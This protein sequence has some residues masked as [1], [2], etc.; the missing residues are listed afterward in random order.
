MI[1][2]IDESATSGFKIIN[3]ETL[4]EEVINLLEK[5]KILFVVEQ[6]RLVGSFTNGDLRRSLPINF[7]L[8]DPIQKIT[9]KKVLFIYENISSKEKMTVISNL[10]HD[11]RYLPI[12]NEKHEIIDVI[13]EDGINTLPNYAVIMAGGK[14]SRLQ[15]LTSETPKPMLK[16]GNK[17]ILQMIIEQ[18]SASGIRKILLSLNYKSDQI[19]HYFGDGSN[20]GIHIEYLHEDNPMGTA[21]CLSLITQQI[22]YP[23]LVMNADI[24][25]DLN[26]NNFLDFH[27][28]S[29]NIATMC[30]VEHAI[31]IPFGVIRVNDS[32]ICDIIEKPIEK[33]LINA[34]IYILNPDVISFVPKG[35]CIDMTSLFQILMA[36]DK[37]VGVFKLDDYWTDIGRLEEY[38]REN[39][40]HMTSLNYSK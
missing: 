18:L 11:F 35:Q 34:G 13:G 1:N 28:K 15:P 26:F 19:V 7:K 2:N 25:T 14:G 8:S 32:L 4:I 36:N 21:G 12:V 23:F 38:E 29:E 17:P 31:K 3:S 9:N 39:K 40:R 30:V 22:N 24:L 37:R 16:I 20:Y 33:H 6:G 5:Y 27:K 10:P